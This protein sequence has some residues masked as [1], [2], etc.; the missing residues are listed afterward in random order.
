MAK[1]YQQ[2]FWS[3]R[4]KGN[5]R[6]RDCGRTRQ[7]VAEID[8]HHREPDR[9][10]HPGTLVGICRRCHLVA[11]HRRDADFIESA[12]APDSPSSLNPKKPSAA[13]LGP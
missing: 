8:V 6:C 7:E 4:E 5:Y 9:G 12:F 2:E 11:R 1:R 13:S 3:D 10:D